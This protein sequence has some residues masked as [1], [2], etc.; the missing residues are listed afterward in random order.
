MSFAFL[1]SARGNVV[2]RSCTTVFGGHI[3]GTFRVGFTMD[4][5]P[6]T[7]PVMHLLHLPFPA[8]HMSTELRERFQLLTTGKAD[9]AATISE[10][11]IEPQKAEVNSILEFG[12]VCSDT[13]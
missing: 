11:W 7:L 4:N 13:L 6:P 3:E 1:P 12:V 5:G 9:V 10:D 2:A 8:F